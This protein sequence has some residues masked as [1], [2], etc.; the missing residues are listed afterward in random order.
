MLYLSCVTVINRSEAGWDRKIVPNR[1]IT[2][3]HCFASGFSIFQQRRCVRH[4]SFP[5]FLSHS[6]AW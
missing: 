3:M 1:I 4:T 2:A 5:V 6:F